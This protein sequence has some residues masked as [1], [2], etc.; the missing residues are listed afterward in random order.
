MSRMELQLKETQVGGKMKKGKYCIIDKNV[1]IGEDVEIG[2][3]CRIEAGCKIGKGT[4]IRS[5]VELRK[6]TII[7][8]KCYIDSGVKS[9]GNCKIGDEVT[10]RYDTII[11]RDVIIEDKVFMAPQCMTEYSDYKRE[12]HSGTIIG[13][14]SFIG[15]NTTI[16]ANIKICPG[17]VIARKS[18]I[19]KD[20]TK[21][22]IY[23]SDKGKIYKIKDLGEEYWEDKT[24]PR[25]WPCV[26]CGRMLTERNSPCPVSVQCNDCRV[27]GVAPACDK[28]YSNEE[29]TEFA[30]KS[31]SS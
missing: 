11:A 25:G 21:A 27:D 1:D 28:D 31:L 7:G 6:N 15:T 14:H 26:T 16:A 23:G 4:V 12:K 9:S 17:T 13:S 24:K 29:D 10:L 18:D 8:E 5:Y 22:A 2:D 3:Y 20:I 30:K 19:N